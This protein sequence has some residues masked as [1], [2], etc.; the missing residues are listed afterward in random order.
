MVTTVQFTLL[1]K[2]FCHVIKSPDLNIVPNLGLYR[3]LNARLPRRTQLE[4]RLTTGQ[5]A[6]DA[7][8]RRV[9]RTQECVCPAFLRNTRGPSFVFVCEWMRVFRAPP[10]CGNEKNLWRYH[11]FRRLSVT[12]KDETGPWP[13][14]LVSVVL[15]VQFE[16]LFALRTLRK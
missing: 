10:F 3:C 11:I 7:F 1:S 5:A 8:A 6:S 14:I 2:D 12:S 13:G 9:R 15:F 4:Q 16:K